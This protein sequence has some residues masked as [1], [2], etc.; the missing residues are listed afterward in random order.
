MAG[1]SA[2][3]VQRPGK[4]ATRPV[5]TIAFHGSADSTV[6]PSNSHGIIEQAK[7]SSDENIVETVETRTTGT[8]QV[9]I[10]TASTALGAPVS[11]H[12]EISDLG[13]AWSG[14]QAGGSY[15]DP[16]GP[17]ASAEMIRFFLETTA[18][19]I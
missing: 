4:A 5:P 14:G 6:H 18:G 8:R 2:Q 12:W 15:T 9:R 13:H 10:T 1:Q 17:D 3:P 11:E 7:P 16:A 19:D